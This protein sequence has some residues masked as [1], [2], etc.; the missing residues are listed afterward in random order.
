MFFDLFKA[1]GRSI[2]TDKEKSLKPTKHTMSFWRR[3]NV[4]TLFDNHMNIKL[5]IIIR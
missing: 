1:Y 4:A 2:C 5:F 3:Y